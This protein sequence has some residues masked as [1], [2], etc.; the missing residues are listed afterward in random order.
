MVKE[1][2][3]SSLI[4]NSQKHFLSEYEKTQTYFL[5]SIKSIKTHFFLIFLCFYFRKI[6]KLKS[7]RKIVINELIGKA[8]KISLWQ[9]QKNY[10]F[11]K[12]VNIVINKTIFTRLFFSLFLRLSENFKNVM[13]YCMSKEN[14]WNIFWQLGWE[15]LIYI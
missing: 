13:S 11:F 2:L 10:R 4:L 3:K 9:K 7:K 8:W 6:N 14:L 15:E 1:F 12:R 5:F